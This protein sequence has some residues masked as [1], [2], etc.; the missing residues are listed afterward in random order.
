MPTWFDSD[1]PS[2]RAATAVVRHLKNDPETNDGRNCYY[3]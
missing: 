3:S 1:L 2:Q